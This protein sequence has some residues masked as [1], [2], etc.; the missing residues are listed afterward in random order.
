MGQYPD[1]AL[2]FPLD[3]VLDLNCKLMGFVSSRNVNMLMTDMTFTM[4]VGSPNNM[5]SE[6][7][8]KARFEQVA[9]V[10]LL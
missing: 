7:L 2:V 1:K 10:F 8:N 4:G 6:V 9:D 5:V 3:E